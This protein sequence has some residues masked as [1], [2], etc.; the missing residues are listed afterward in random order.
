MPRIGRDGREPD[1]ETLP[2]RPR[3]AEFSPRF[4]E[5]EESPG[6]VASE[7][8]RS[9][10][11]I[12][13]QLVFGDPRA[14]SAG[15]VAFGQRFPPPIN[16]G[17]YCPE[18]SVNWPRLPVSDTVAPIVYEDSSR[19]VDPVVFSNVLSPWGFEVVDGRLEGGGPEARYLAQVRPPG[20]GLEPVEVDGVPTFQPGLT[21]DRAVLRAFLAINQ[22]REDEILAFAQV[23]GMLGTTPPTIII[24][25]GS[26][27]PERAELIEAWKGHH[28]ELREALWLSTTKDPDEIAKRIGHLPVYG[29]SGHSPDESGFVV[30]IWPEHVLGVAAKPGA[31]MSEQFQPLPIRLRALRW[32]SQA[33]LMAR[34]AIARNLKERAFVGIRYDRDTQK[35]RLVATASGLLGYLWIELERS[36]ET[37]TKERVCPSCGKP[38]MVNP[39]TGSRRKREFC[40]DSCRHRAFRARKR[41]ARE[42]HAQGVSIQQIAETLASKPTTVRGWVGK[43]SQSHQ[44]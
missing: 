40:S 36:M 17:Q 23:H 6:L 19:P 4:H 22:E 21:S 2:G 1:L 8:A 30:G 29:E 35:Q 24:R 14:S 3:N 10:V 25:R 16:V 34:A 26:D 15:R 31:S 9:A 38:F 41:R 37:E 42:L 43:G 13:A 11:E 32:E 27:T 18:S 5:R 28:A 33:R 39:V 7:S 12:G 44:S 20:G